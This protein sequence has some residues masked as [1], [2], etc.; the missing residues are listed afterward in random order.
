MK[1]TKK[2]VCIILLIAELAVLALCFR[3]YKNYSDNRAYTTADLV[4]QGDEI[5]PT[6]SGY[7]DNNSYAGTNKKVCTPQMQLHDGI[8][9]MTMQ[10]ETTATPGMSSVSI[11]SVD[12]DILGVNG[13]T[14]RLYPDEHSVSYRF[15]VNGSHTQIQIGGSLSSESDGYLLIRGVDVQYIPTLTAAN[16]TLTLLF[17]LACADLVIYILLFRRKETAELC[18]KNALMISGMAFIFFFAM[19]P[20]FTV[21]QQHG[22]DLAFHLQR[23]YSLAE[24]LRAGQFPVRMD[25]YWF[26][27]YGYPL[28]ITYCNLFLLPSA[29]LKLLGYPLQFTYKVYIALMTALTMWTAYHA[30]YIIGE[31]KQRLALAGCGIY[32]L[33]FYRLVDVY[34]RAAVGEYAAMAFLPLLILGFWY[35]Y[36]DETIKKSWVPLTIGAAGI[37][38]SHV[39]SIIIVIWF[40]VPF[41]IL[42]GKKTFTRERLLQLLKFA[43]MTVL[44][45]IWFIYPFLT[46]YAG[47]AIGISSG[48]GSNLIRRAVFL[49]SQ[50]ELDFDPLG[51]GEDFGM[52]GKSPTGYGIAAAFILVVSLYLLLKGRE[53]KRHR[54]IGVLSVMMLFCVIVT[55]SA[56]FYRFLRIYLPAVY[57]IIGNIQFCFRFFE[58]GTQFLLVLFLL[59]V[60]ELNDKFGKQVA[61][62]FLVL[63]CAVT[64][65]ESNRMLSKQNATVE[66]EYAYDIPADHYIDN[67][68]YLPDG[69][70]SALVFGESGRQPEAPDSVQAS[71]VSDGPISG[72]VQV[73]NETGAASY[74]DLFV[75]NYPGYHVYAQDGTELSTE[76]GDNGRLRADIPQNYDGTISFR[77]EEPLSWRASELIS[78]AGLVGFIV[79]LKKREKANR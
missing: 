32:T 58:I 45:T 74:V 75:F 50:F 35:L 33:S 52:V 23:I 3:S 22:D 40:A 8:Y 7:V 77:F 11:E 46:Y 56:Q 10:Y 21:Y 68:E 36:H 66:G 43:G 4:L 72:T 27:D 15:N 49:P 5:D 44:L 55:S 76:A 6:P 41:F 1:T 14:Y 2:A 62:A 47:G 24:G 79:C 71:V 19:L 29:V 70:N 48:T 16:R 65:I 61:A 38:L 60:L 59:D 30:S 69:C 26:N 12:D 78:L 31:K 13:D 73:K 67:P 28:G 25:P 37:A 51:S 9:R 42:M 54:E 20:C 57:H 64:F 34:H 53:Q 63:V 18:R 17:W 39:L